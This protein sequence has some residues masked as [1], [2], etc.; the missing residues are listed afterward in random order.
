MSTVQGT[1]TST[2]LGA[3]SSQTCPGGPELV[4]GAVCVRDPEG[5]EWEVTRPVIALCRCSRSARLPWCD[6]T[7]QLLVPGWDEPGRPQPRAVQ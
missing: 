5:H 2:C 1:L 7:H 6:G 4:R 3:T